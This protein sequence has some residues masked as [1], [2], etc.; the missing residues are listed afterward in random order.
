MTQERLPAC[1]L[2]GRRDSAPFHTDRVRRYLRCGDCRLVFVPSSFWLS[3]AQEKAVYDL[4]RNDP[5]DPDYRRFLSRLSTPLLGRLAPNSRGLDFGCGPGP[6]LAQ[7]LTARGHRTD[8]YDPFYYDDASVFERRYD[9]ITA[10]EVVEHLRKPARVW[11]RLFAILR[12]GGWLGIMTKLVI[13]GDAFRRWH[14]I[15]DPTHIC[16]YSRETFDYLVRRFT[17]RLWVVA[18]DVLLLQKG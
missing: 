7:L 6:A 15:R 13:D 8:L 14:Y 12:P 5:A 16:F 11:D 9:F 18:R 4:H 10:T 1:P 17:A 2:C 3:A